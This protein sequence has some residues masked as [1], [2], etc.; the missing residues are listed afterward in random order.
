MFRKILVPVDFN[1]LTRRTLDLAVGLAR[2]GGG[3]VVLFT[4]VDDSF[5]NPDILSFQL[6]WADY[7]RHLR[8][9]AVNRLEGL[10]H[11]AAAERESEVCVVRGNPARM[12]ARFAQEEGCDL[13][14]MATHGASGLHHALVG[15]VTRKVLHLASVPVL[16]VRLGGE[17]DGGAQAGRA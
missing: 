3:R 5:P 11:E 15:S 10:R 13:I 8:D 17:P 2:T 6:P 16:V 1:D 14:V 4:V 12:I 9:E 7:H